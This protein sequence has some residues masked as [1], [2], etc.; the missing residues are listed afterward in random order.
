MTPVVETAGLTRLRQRNNDTA[1][2]WETVLP[3]GR[4]RP[5]TLARSDEI[6]CAEKGIKAAGRSGGPTQLAHTA[7][8]TPRE[9][10]RRKRSNTLSCR[11]KMHRPMRQGR[12]RTETLTRRWIKHAHQGADDITLELPSQDASSC[13]RISARHRSGSK[14]NTV[15]KPAARQTHR[16]AE[17]I[18]R[19]AVGLT[20]HR[21]RTGAPLAERILALRPPM[22][23]FG[24]PPTTRLTASTPPT[25]ITRG[26]RDQ[27]PEP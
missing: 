10:R 14:S 27:A 19:L 2:P 13:V 11:G 6:T 21:R 23:A 22:L 7:A 8:D 3:R 17:P 25:G 24:V 16:M 12:L 20:S 9:R 15:P 5:N 4:I 18:S 26:G 1:E